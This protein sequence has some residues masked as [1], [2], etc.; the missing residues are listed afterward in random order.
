M[1]SGYEYACDNGGRQVSTSGPW[2]FYR[3][4]EGKIKSY[5]HPDP[6]S[7]EAKNHG[8][9]GLMGST[10][11]IQCDRVFHRIVIIDYKTPSPESW[12]VWWGMYEPQDIYKDEDSVK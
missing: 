10:Y 8:I 6:S 7:E 12:L 9:A 2:E 11:C 3:K 1:G 4:D 5:G